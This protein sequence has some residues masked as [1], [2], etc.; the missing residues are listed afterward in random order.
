MGQAHDAWITL[1]GSSAM[2]TEWG[3]SESLRAE[4]E[5]ALLLDA[6]N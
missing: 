4:N 2:A 5:P 6:V 3:F 1:K